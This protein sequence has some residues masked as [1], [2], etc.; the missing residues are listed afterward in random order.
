MCGDKGSKGTA[1]LGQSS[2]AHGDMDGGSRMVRTHGD[3]DSQDTRTAISVGAELGPYMGGEEQMGHHTSNSTHQPAP[4]WRCAR[5]AARERR[6]T[7]PTIYLGIL[8]V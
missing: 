3:D 7:C 8:G 4:Q 2:S 5:Q 6:T 1:G